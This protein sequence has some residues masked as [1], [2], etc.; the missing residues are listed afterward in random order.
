MK[1]SVEEK[2][3]EEEAAVATDDG[4]KGR[5]GRGGGLHRVREARRPCLSSVDQKRE[6]SLA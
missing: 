2:M 4:G 3:E 1:K 5:R 6:R